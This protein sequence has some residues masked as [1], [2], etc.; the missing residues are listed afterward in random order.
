[1]NGDMDKLLALLLLLI[2]APAILC[3][4]LQVVSCVAQVTVNVA[5]VALP[6]LLLCALLVAIGAGFGAGMALRNRLPLP[7]TD[8]AP[9]APGAVVPVRRAP[10][11]AEDDDGHHGGVR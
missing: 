10:E 8:I 1:M 6:W 9:L 7:R 11:V 2:L 5:L 4:A 3:A